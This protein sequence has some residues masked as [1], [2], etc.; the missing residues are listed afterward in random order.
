MEKKG[1]KRNDNFTVD[2]RMGLIDIINGHKE[3][4]EDKRSDTTTNKKKTAAWE[5]V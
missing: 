1:Q 5:D 3:I 2:Q 4:I